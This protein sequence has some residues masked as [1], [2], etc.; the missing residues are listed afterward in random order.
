MVPFVSRLTPLLGLAL[1]C[2]CGP[3]GDASTPAPGVVEPVA[4]SFEEVS[5]F[6][7]DEVQQIV[8]LDTQV[9]PGQR[10]RFDMGQGSI[11]IETLRVTDQML[12]FHYTPEV[13]GGYAIYECTVPVSPSAVEFHI[14]PDGTP[15]ETSFDLT[16]CTLVRSGNLLLEQ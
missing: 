16:K 11:T 15:G 12:T 3:S 9:A 7:F 13:E 4:D 10:R 6:R 1:A 14:N 5:A 8:Y 2:G